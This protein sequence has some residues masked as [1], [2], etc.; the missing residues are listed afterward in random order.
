M[1]MEIFKRNAVTYVSVDLFLGWEE[2]MV[3]F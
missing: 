3:L 1:K 2:M